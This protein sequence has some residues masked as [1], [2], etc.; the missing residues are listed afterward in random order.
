MKKFHQD[1][2]K[3]PTIFANE[4]WKITQYPVI[5][6]HTIDKLI[7]NIDISLKNKD[8]EKSFFI[9][10]FL[11]TFHKGKNEKEKVKFGYI[12][13]AISNILAIS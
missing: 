12:V 13:M 5:E 4:E 7:S 2:S 10:N 8:F 11:P 1:L 9:Y 6:W 3:K